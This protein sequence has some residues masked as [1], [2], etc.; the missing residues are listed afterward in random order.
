MSIY[1]FIYQTLIYHIFPF[2]IKRLVYKAAFFVVFSEHFFTARELQVLQTHKCPDKLL[3]V[4]PKLISL[5]MISRNHRISA[6]EHRL[7]EN[8]LLFQAK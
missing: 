8:K 6:F 2:V 5:K 7:L 3:C 4:L 1:F